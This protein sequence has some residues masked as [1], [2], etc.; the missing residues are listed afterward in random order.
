MSYRLNETRLTAD[1]ALTNFSSASIQE[2]IATTRCL[3]K[4]ASTLSILAIDELLKL[5]QHGS[6]KSRYLTINEVIL[7]PDLK[8]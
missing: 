5:H 3:V 4:V 6:R 7:A 1:L 8:D 2:Q